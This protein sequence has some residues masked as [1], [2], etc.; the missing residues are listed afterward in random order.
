MTL[1]AY[2]TSAERLQLIPSTAKRTAGVQYELQVNRG[3][4]TATEIVSVDFKVGACSLTERQMLMSDGACQG[5]TRLSFCKCAAKLHRHPARQAE[6]SQTRAPDKAGLLFCQ[7]D[8]IQLSVCQAQSVYVGLALLGSNNA[9]TSPVL[10][11]ASA[12]P[13]LH[14]AHC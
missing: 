9:D 11:P 2:Y 14:A 4:A 6:G 3:G 8:H 13:C 10:Y 1:Q 5:L 12:A 7:P